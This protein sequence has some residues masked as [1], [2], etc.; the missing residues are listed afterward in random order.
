MDRRSNSTI[1]TVWCHGRTGSPKSHRDSNLV[2]M[3]SD[4]KVNNGSSTKIDDRNRKDEL[5]KVQLQDLIET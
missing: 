1:D 4:L 5:E 3:M 2:I